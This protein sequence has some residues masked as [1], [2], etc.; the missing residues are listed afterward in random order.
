MSGL[1]P[2]SLL[3]RFSCAYK[4]MAITA[5]AKDGGIGY[6]LTTVRPDDVQETNEFGKLQALEDFL[7]ETS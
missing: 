6:T 2:E 5:F 3:R 4:D 7:C 1:T